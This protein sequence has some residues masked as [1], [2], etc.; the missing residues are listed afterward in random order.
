M[1]GRPK[2][3]ACLSSA[4]ETLIDGQARLLH[5]KNANLYSLVYKG[6]KYQW[7]TLVGSDGLLLAHRE[8]DEPTRNVLVG[9]AIQ[10]EQ[11]TS[12]TKPNPLGKAAAGMTPLGL[13]VD[14]REKNQPPNTPYQRR[15]LDVVHVLL[16]VPRPTDQR[17]LAKHPT[18]LQNV[19]NVVSTV[20]N[21]HFLELQQGNNANTIA[22]ALLRTIRPWLF[23]RGRPT[24]L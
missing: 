8:T 11:S 2:F 23:G 15:R 19:K 10:S 6:G 5:V 18:V 4:I 3:T 13:W 21:A 17:R 1:A 12:Q 9:V 16:V 22:N 20:E 7:L 14:V 24:D